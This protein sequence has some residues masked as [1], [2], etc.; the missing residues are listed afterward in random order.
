[1]EMVKG[2]QRLRRADRIDALLR[3]LASEEVLPFDF[4][5]AVLAG[6]FYGDLERTGQPIGRSDPMIAAIAIQQNLTLATGN[7]RHFER[8]QNL[9]YPLKLEN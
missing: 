6:K 8:I 9:G 7:T 1:M 3:Q 4:D 2:F 5:V